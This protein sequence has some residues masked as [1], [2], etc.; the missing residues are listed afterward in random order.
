M[1]FGF[2]AV[3]S[4]YSL[5]LLT[6]ISGDLLI[7]AMVLPAVFRGLP[8][9]LQAGSVASTILARWAYVKWGC[10]AVLAATSVTRYAAWEQP[11]VWIRARHVA[12]TFLALTLAV[13][14]F[15]IAPRLQAMR[16]LLAT[17]AA[18]AIRP[19]FAK[20]HQYSVATGMAGVFAGLV[21]L[22]FS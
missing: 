14:T 19:E 16:P 9:R 13:E 11:T 15:L 3:Q 12:L 18:E 7:G 21:A 5:A 2:A 6:W 22:F 17:P 10:L 4:L 20:V 1:N 8:D